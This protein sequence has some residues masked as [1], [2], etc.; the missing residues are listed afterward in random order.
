MI[1][2]SLRPE[3]VHAVCK[4]R[5]RW[6]FGLTARSIGLLTAGFFL[7][8]PGFWESRLSYGMLIWDGTGPSGGP[9]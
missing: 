1:S 8:I 6:S 4:P 3:P 2:S 7:V 5:G 9:A